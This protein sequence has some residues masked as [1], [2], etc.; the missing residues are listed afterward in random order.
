MKFG[1]KGFGCKTA[2]YF[3]CFV[4]YCSNR[5]FLKPSKS[6]FPPFPSSISL[7]DVDHVEGVLNSRIPLL[8]FKRRSTKRGVGVTKK[9][10][11]GRVGLPAPPSR[12][13]FGTLPRRR[14]GCPARACTGTGRAFGSIPSPAPW[15]G[16]FLRFIL[17]QRWTGLC[18][19]LPAFP[20]HGHGAL[21]DRSVHTL[22][23]LFLGPLKKKRR[24]EWTHP[25][26]TC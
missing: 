2:N 7:A 14:V 18:S 23:I 5:R 19:T 25:S 15:A 9:T 1:P 12:G 22:G 20:R 17:V 4:M 16:G 21:L 3:F 10:V 6:S 8:F 13:P 11:V 26:S 24:E